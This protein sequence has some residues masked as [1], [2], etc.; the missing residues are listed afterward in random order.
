[1]TSF[2]TGEW[3]QTA[4]EHED[5]TIGV[6]YKIIAV[7]LGAVRIIDD[8]GDEHDILLSDVTLSGRAP[9]TDANAN[10]DYEEAKANA[11]VTSD[12]EF[13]KGDVLIYCDGTP[14]N[15]PR[16]VTRCTATCVWFEETYSMPFNPI[17]F[18]KEGYDE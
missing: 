15:E 8:V 5:V 17:E 7:L 13:D 16:T 2:K 6:A 1:M 10:D 4:D 11:S 18:T 9:V 12:G 3:I 14:T